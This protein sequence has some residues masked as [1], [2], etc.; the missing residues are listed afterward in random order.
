ME[1]Y[2]GDTIYKYKLDQFTDDVC[3]V[4]IKFEP[5][6]DRIKMKQLDV[7]QLFLAL[8]DAFTG[9]KENLIRVSQL[10]VLPLRSMLF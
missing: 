1:Q 5:Y 3:D 9:D 4:V 6:L 8:K 10:V 2:H 7:L